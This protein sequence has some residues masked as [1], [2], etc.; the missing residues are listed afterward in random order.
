MNKTRIEQIEDLI[1]LLLVAIEIEAKQLYTTK[2]ENPYE[3]SNCITTIK[4]L[5]RNI[6]SLNEELNDEY[7]HIKIYEEGGK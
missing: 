1:S 4:Q 3:L 5:D 6:Q 2:W 7:Y